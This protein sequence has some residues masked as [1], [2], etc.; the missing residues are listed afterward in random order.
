MVA[1]SIRYRWRGSLWSMWS[2]RPMRSIRSICAVFV[3]AASAAASGHTMAQA[4]A[5]VPQAPQTPQAAIAFG[6][7]ARIPDTIE[8]RA[9]A[10][11]VCHGKQGRAGSDGYY[12][13]IAGKPAGYLYNQLRNFRD[14]Q[15]TYPVMTALIENMSDDYLRELAQFFS[16]Q[17]PPYPAPQRT[18]ATADQLA[19]GQQLVTKGNGKAPACIAC[20]GSALTGVAPAIPG[21]IG[22]PRDYLLGQIGAWKN[23]TR[24]A[25]KP[26]CMAQVIRNLSDAEI[27]AA[28]SWLAAQNAPVS[29]LPASSAPGKLPLDCGSMPNSAGIPSKEGVK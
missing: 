13:R 6:A 27:S 14:G 7:D 3:L 22:L 16:D 4:A 17:H 1:V 5:V 8:Q 21:L 25:L 23:G 15:R 29:A 12:P 9:A 20:H 18:A 11:I 24:H 28:A 19:Q 2:M 26:D 10:C